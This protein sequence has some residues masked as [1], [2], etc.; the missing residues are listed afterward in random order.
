M[1]QKVCERNEELIEWLLSPE[2]LIQLLNYNAIYYTLFDGL[3]KNEFGYV[4]ASLNKATLIW[5]IF[6]V[7]FEHISH[8]FL[9]FL[10]LTL[11]T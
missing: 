11:N 2:Q 3:K 4:T 8:L 1:K 5:S 10:L 6:I 7:N 9:V